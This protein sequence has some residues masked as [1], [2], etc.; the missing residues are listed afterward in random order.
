MLLKKSP[1]LE[2][3]P[4][5]IDL[6]GQRAPETIDWLGRRS[7]KALELLGQR[8]PKTIDLLGQQAPETIDLL[9]RRSPKTIDLLGQRNPKTIDLLGQRNPKTHSR[10]I[11]AKS[12]DLLWGGGRALPTQC[13]TQVA[14]FVRTSSRPGS[15]LGRT[16]QPQLF[17]MSSRS[18]RRRCIG[19]RRREDVNQG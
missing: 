8:S 14:T 13:Y 2:H 19:S 9:G 11:S 1:N 4:E 18:W 16:L 12:C 6:L 10:V 7:P 3:R 17:V 5:T 15:E